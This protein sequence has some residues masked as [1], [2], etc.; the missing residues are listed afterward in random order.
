MNYYTKYQH[1][2]ITFDPSK[3][4]EKPQTDTNVP[5]QWKATYADAYNKFDYW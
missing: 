1:H 5:R 2:Y 4:E 3:P